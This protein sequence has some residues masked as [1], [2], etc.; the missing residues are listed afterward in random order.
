MAGATTPRRGLLAR[1]PAALLPPLLLIL[2]AALLAAGPGALATRMHPFYRHSAARACPPDGFS[3]VPNLN[4]TAYTA[5]P[6]YVQ[7]QLPVSYQGEDPD[8]YL[9]CVRAVY[10]PLKVRP[11]DRGWVIFTPGTDPD[12]S[13]A[14][15]LTSGGGADKATQSSDNAG[16]SGAASSANI[17]GVVTGGS[18]GD[19]GGDD[20]S[21]GD[22]NE[23]VPTIIEVINTA[24]RGGVNGPA[25]GT[26]P[27]NATLNDYSYDP[28]QGDN[29]TDNGDDNDNDNNDNDN[30]DND[31]N[32]SGR[33]LGAPRRPAVL[34]ATPDPVA[35]GTP[36]EAATLLVGS[37]VL[38]PRLLGLGWR[39]GWGQYWVVA[40]MPSNDSSLGYD[41]AIVSAGPPSYPSRGGGCLTAPEPPSPRDPDLGLASSRFMD[42]VNNVLQAKVEAVE[43]ITQAVTGG[44]GGG[45]GGG[46]WFLSRKPVDPQG[47]SEME[48]TAR[49]LG[50]DTSGLVDV[51]Q[52]GCAYDQPS[53]SSSSASSNASAPAAAAEANTTAAPAANET[54]AT[55]STNETAPANETA[56]PAASGTATTPAP[57]S[58]TTN[59]TTAPAT[60]TP[61]ATAAATTP[62]TTD[63]TT[64]TPGNMTN[65]TNGMSMSGNATTTAGGGSNVSTTAAP[66]PPLSSFSGV[67]SVT[68][69]NGPTAT[70]PGK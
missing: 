19:Q 23:P 58:D 31:N 38:L 40:V 70:E 15:N 20:S 54:V 37:P 8:R 64:T 52:E 13:A 2:A 41:W 68:A 32:D 69:A 42:W 3:P 65:M 7:R 30:N 33:L 46:L 21:S 16:G 44:G 61:A 29:D 26:S 5:A 67:P 59:V 57:P 17:S 62:A 35:A 27:L 6:W 25:V 43:D 34:L 48:A 36:A 12:A 1:A 24:R 50:F 28:D 4:L 39:L 55:P 56:V 51:R 10:T 66:P 45:R 11:S 53:S 9:Y 63:N 18:L 49:Q 60:T 22:G 14:S 47:T